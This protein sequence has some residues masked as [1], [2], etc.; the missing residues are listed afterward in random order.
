MAKSV[1]S[2]C[3]MAQKKGVTVDTSHSKTHWAEELGVSEAS[4]R[5]HFKHGDEPRLGQDR[6][7]DAP[8]SI[9][10]YD[11][12]EPKE[13]SLPY[14]EV[15]TGTEGEMS[16]VIQGEKI[17]KEA[18]LRKFG[19]DPEQV[20][21]VG[22]LEETHWMMGGEWQHRY[23]FQ[24]TRKGENPDGEDDLTVEDL[25]LLYQE[26]MAKKPVAV[27][28]G[29]S[30]ERATVVVW[31]DI[32]V[33]KV[34]SRGGTPELIERVKR[35]RAALQ[36]YMKENPA[37]Q[38][39]FLSVGDEVES[40][41][42][43]PQ[44]A[45][46]NDLSFPDQLD[47]ELT[48][49]MEMISDITDMYKKVTVAGCSS[50]HCRWRAGK[51]ALG[52]PKDDYGLFI[53]KQLEKFLG[54]NEKFADVTFQYPEDWDETMALDVL[55]TKVGL[56]HGHQVN[57][58]N[59][60]EAWW[61]KQAFGAQATADADILL[62]GHFHTFRAQPMGR[63][64]KTGKNRWWLQAPTLDNGSDWFRNLQGSDS[65]DGLLV[66]QID[67]DGLDLQSLTIL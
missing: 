55:G 53:K 28:D 59:G 21:I 18:I 64:M 11:D 66:F 39:F 25:P 9:S 58:P 51:N 17:S 20:K 35:K 36:T 5:R 30:I 1:C 57:N 7:S 22:T 13:P 14:K 3:V 23:K 12:T 56:A 4:V 42:N 60:V 15:W 8:V 62:T 50:N 10:K 24:T 63:S 52:A 47:L 67:K 33:G 41:E 43:T 49:E 46:T 32:Q 2:V 38:A 19:H 65:D 45:F 37:G 34:G 26:V 29:T 16:V 48:F 31:A 40:F 54:M 44:Q 61:T 27:Q 6:P